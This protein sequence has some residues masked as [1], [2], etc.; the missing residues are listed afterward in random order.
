M[1]G[2][3][4]G[5]PRKVRID[6]DGARGREDV[7]LAPLPLEYL[8]KYVEEVLA[9]YA[10]E[11]KAAPSYPKTHAQRRLVRAVPRDVTDDRVNAAV[12]QFDQ[13]EEV[14]AEKRLSARPVR[15]RAEDGGRA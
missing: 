11:G 10:G 8:L 14:S 7:V 1:A 12:G 3:L 15:G 6:N 4:D 5:R 9:A 13:V 2:R